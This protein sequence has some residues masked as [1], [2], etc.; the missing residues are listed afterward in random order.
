MAAVEG[1]TPRGTFLQVHTVDYRYLR[2]TPNMK[3]RL[4]ILTMDSNNYSGQGVA[5]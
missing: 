1:P 5:A 4:S 3:L 2:R